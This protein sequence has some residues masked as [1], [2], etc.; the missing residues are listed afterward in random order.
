[1]SSILSGSHTLPS[2]MGVP[3]ALRGKGF[4]GESLVSSITSGSY[5]LH[6]F[7]GGS[8]SAEGEGFDGDISFKVI[9]SKVS[10]V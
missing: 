8:L 6:F 10:F 4:D 3:W 2:S 7:H 9:H 1:M 5:T